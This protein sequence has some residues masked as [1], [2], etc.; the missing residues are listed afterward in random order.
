MVPTMLD[1]L[2]RGAHRTT[3][4]LVQGEDLRR[5]GVHTVPDQGRR[6]RAQMSSDYSGAQPAVSG[7]WRLSN[8]HPTQGVI[9]CSLV[10]AATLGVSRT[11][12]RSSEG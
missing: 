11:R 4:R 6:E 8:Q 10:L 2:H 12:R 3:D 7:R 1:R 5:F 9:T